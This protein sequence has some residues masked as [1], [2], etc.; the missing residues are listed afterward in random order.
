MPNKNL[1]QPRQKYPH[2]HLTQTA[3]NTSRQENTKETK[4]DLEINQFILAIICQIRKSKSLLFSR[5]L[6][7]IVT[8][9]PKSAASIPD[10]H[11]A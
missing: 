3:K 10:L 1:S 6:R 5:T 11:L 7:E 8:L 2:L 9:S 4:R